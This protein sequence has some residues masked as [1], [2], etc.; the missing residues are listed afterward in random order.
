[1]TGFVLRL[2]LGSKFFVNHHL[3]NYPYCSSD[4]VPTFSFLMQIQVSI[5]TAAI[6]ITNL[7]CCQDILPCQIYSNSRQSTWAGLIGKPGYLRVFR[8][9]AGQ[10]IYADRPLAGPAV[11][12]LR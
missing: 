11:V 9:H 6:W 3:P 4:I 5:F 8:L 12:H 2:T 10:F 7:N 1:M